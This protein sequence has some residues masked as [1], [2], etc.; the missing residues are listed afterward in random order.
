[1]FFKFKEFIISF[2]YKLPLYIFIFVIINFFYFWWYDSSLGLKTYLFILFI[3]LLQRLGFHILIKLYNTLL[4]SFFNT[5]FYLMIKRNFK[6]Y[7]RKFK[8]NK[9]DI[10]Q[11]SSWNFRIKK[12]SYKEG[13]GDLISYKLFKESELKHEKLDFLQK[14][15]RKNKNLTNFKL[16]DELNLTISE[17]NEINK[18][19]YKDKK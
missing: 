3:Y 10:I 14:E 5:S 8:F 15:L 17:L 9:L 13:K 19:F 1:M 18:K 2:I 12:I 4:D 11:S 7:K 16:V 6:Y